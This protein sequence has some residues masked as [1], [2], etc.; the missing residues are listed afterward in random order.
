MLEV[1]RST[2]ILGWRHV[3]LLCGGTAAFF[4]QLRHPVI[5]LASPLLNELLGFALGLGLPWLTVVA[6]FRIGRW[7]SKT[8]AIVAGAS[9]LLY[10]FVFVL[11]SAIAGF[12]YRNGHNL[13]FDRFAET[14]WKGTDVRF[15]RTNG[16]QLRISGLSF[17]RRGLCSPA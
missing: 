3:I 17:G 10:T 13:S 14:Q 5:R 11:V 7:W 15:Y 4:W 12:A 1:N 2:S 16:G 6:I 8:V 9:L